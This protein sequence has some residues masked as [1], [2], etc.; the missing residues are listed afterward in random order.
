MNGWKNRF[1]DKESLQE[2]IF[3]LNS[4]NIPVVLI[5]KNDDSCYND[6]KVNIG[7]NLVGLEEQNSLS[8]TWHLINKSQAFITADSGLY[9]LAGSTDT[10]IIVTGWSK[11]PY[12][13]ELFRKGKRGYKCYNV[14]GTCPIYCSNDINVKVH[15]SIYGQ[16]GG[17]CFLNTNFSCKPSARVIFDKT[18]EILNANNLIF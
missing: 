17:D 18:L 5:G 2:L 6:L 10:N 3:L 13:N 14:K 15:S 4:K 8:Q 9:I 16:F 12:Y 1:I 7:I 11:D